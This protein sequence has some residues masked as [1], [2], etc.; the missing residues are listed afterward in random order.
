MS[1]RTT[2]A[3]IRWLSRITPLG[4]TKLHVVTGS[5]DDPDAYFVAAIAPCDSGGTYLRVRLGKDADSEHQ[6][7]RTAT[8]YLEVRD[9]AKNICGGKAVMLIRDLEPVDDIPLS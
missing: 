6:I 2:Q 9:A 7:L 8:P 3:S 1:T 5:Y 4:N